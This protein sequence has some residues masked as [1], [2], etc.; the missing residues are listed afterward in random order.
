MDLESE[1][2]HCVIFHLVFSPQSRLLTNL[3]PVS[4]RFCKFSPQ[5]KLWKLAVFNWE[6]LLQK[7]DFAGILIMSCR[8]PG[9]HYS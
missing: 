2:I 4:G 7:S 1:K 3:Q 8:L 9:S 5:Q 6:N